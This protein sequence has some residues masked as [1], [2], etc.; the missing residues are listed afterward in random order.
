[1]PNRQNYL[2]IRQQNIASYKF[3]LKMYVRCFRIYNIID[4]LNFYFAA[5]C[6]ALEI[7]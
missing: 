7:L 6:I 1:M 2:L 3:H 4:C 5:P